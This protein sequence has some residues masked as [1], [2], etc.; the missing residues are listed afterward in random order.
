MSDSKRLSSREAGPG[1]WDGDGTPLDG[2]PGY[3]ARKNGAGF[4]GFLTV[5]AMVVTILAAI[6]AA[7]D[8]RQ[9]IE[10]SSDITSLLQGREISAVQQTALAAMAIG[11]VVI[12]YI[13]ARC[14]YSLH[15][16]LSA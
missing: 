14:L 3:D 4:F 5:C 12:P 15:R 16:M 6:S 9:A 2:K 1:A 8:L 7:F 10:P 11:K 13:V